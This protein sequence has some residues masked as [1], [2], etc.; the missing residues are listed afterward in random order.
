M[1]PI[2]QAQEAH[3]YVRQNQNIGKVILVVKEGAAV[4]PVVPPDGVKV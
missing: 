1:F 4:L 3:A 2:E